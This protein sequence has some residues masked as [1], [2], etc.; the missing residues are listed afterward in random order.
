MVYSHGHGG[1]LDSYNCYHDRK[2]GGYHCHRGKNKGKSYSSK[3]EVL[4]DIK[5]QCFQAISPYSEVS[6]L[7]VKNQYNE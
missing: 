2:K 5:S 6:N 7:H 4:K 3:E 1:G